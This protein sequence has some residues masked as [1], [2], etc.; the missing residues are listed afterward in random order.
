MRMAS[1]VGVSTAGI[2]NDDRGFITPLI[3]YL[4]RP[5][6]SSLDALLAVI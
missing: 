6:I 4:V 3:R 5:M 2:S 1:D